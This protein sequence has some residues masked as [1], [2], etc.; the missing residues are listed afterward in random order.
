MIEAERAKTPGKK[1]KSAQDSNAPKQEQAD[2]EPGEE[3][4][5]EGST[6]ITLI[7]S[8]LS[9][10]VKSTVK[11]VNQYFL[12]YFMP[13][14]HDR[15]QPGSPAPQRKIGYNLLVLRTLTIVLGSLTSAL[16]TEL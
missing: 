12:L 5:D 3:T 6:S 9:N 7:L 10:R 14:P 16:A 4:E 8:S 11:N 2:G 13:E 1:A 15:I